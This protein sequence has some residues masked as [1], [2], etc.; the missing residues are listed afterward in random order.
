MTRV[1][2]IS[3]VILLISGSVIY[4]AGRVRARIVGGGRRAHPGER[5]SPAEDGHTRCGAP[6]RFAV[7][8]PLPAH[9]GAVGWGARSAPVAGASSEIGTDAHGGEEPAIRP[10][11]EPGRVPETSAVERTESS[12][13]GGLDAVA[14]GEPAAARVAPVAR[15]ARGPDRGAGPGGGRSRAA[16]RGSGPAD[17]PPGRGPVVALAFVL[18]LGPVERFRKRRKL[19]SYLG[20]NPREHSSGG[21]Q[22][23]GAISRQGSTMLRCLLLEASQTAARLGPESPRAYQRLKFRRVS[24]VAKVAIARRLAVRLYWMLRA[25]VDYAQLFRMSSSP[26]AAVPLGAGSGV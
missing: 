9:L 26:S 8:E 22:H 7:G 4:L 5:S 15:S 2:L 11:D 23:V 21:H 20:L 10:G 17:D 19:V 12:G 18:T 6:A 13:T 25:R 3:L 24:S 16:A 14:L 1:L